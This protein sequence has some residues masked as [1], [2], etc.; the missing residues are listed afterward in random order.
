LVPFNQAKGEDYHYYK[1]NNKSLSLAGGNPRGSGS[2][3]FNTPENEDGTAL[4][5][6]VFVEGDFTIDASQVDFENH[7]FAVS[8]ELTIDVDGNSN[9]NG[10]INWKD[11]YLYGGE[12]I[13]IN[14]T[15]D[16]N[17]SGSMM[18]PGDINFDGIDNKIVESSDNLRLDLLPEA[19]VETIIGDPD[20]QEI[21]A[22]NIDVN[23]N[24]VKWTEKKGN[25]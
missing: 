3:T 21:T 19:F 14:G 15:G 11:S 8:G 7:Y 23:E 24:E 22:G 10:D 4:P 6:I 20:T 5:R 1:S 9:G 25:N 12:G 17:F 18:T 13:N 16:L 2:M